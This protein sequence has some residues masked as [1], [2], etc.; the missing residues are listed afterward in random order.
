MERLLNPQVLQFTVGIILCLFG[1]ICYWG[2][3]HVLGALAGGA[4]GVAAGVLASYVG[5]LGQ[6]SLI[7]IGISALVGAVGGIFLIRML[8][9]GFFLLSG[10]FIGLLLGLQVA[11]ILHDTAWAQQFQWFKGGAGLAGAVLGALAFLLLSR[12]I[13][14]I[15]TSVAGAFLTALSFPFRDPLL[16]FLIALFLALIIQTGVVRHFGFSRTAPRAAQNN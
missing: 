1:W 13:I 5:Q 6:N 14:I 12:H 7:V 16:I 15:I 2:G 3:L 11:V 8:H 4:F 9:R 10:I